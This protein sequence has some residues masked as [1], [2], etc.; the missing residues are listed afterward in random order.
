MKI[1][2]LMLVICVLGVQSCVTTGPGGEKSFIAISDSQEV[3]IGKNVDTEV[4]AKEKILPDSTWQRYLAEVGQK[5][6]KVC[7]RQ[8][9]DYHFAVIE[10]DQIN[11]FATPGGYV[12]FYSGILNMIDNEA[13]LAAVM[14]HEISHVVARHSVKSLQA[15]VGL[16]VLLQLALGEKSQGSWG[17]VAGLAMNLGMT[18]YGR[19]HELEADKFGVFYMQKAGYNPDG[20]R[21]MFGKLAALTGDKQQGFFESLT[22]DHPDTQERLA[23]INAEIAQMPRSVDALPKFEQRYQEMKKRLPPAKK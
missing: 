12:Y 2:R 8:E 9:I 1:M 7:D 18:G 22:S 11:A 23:K 3:E 15:S 10:S 6:V 16:D 21:T 14:A 13:E 4:R 19:S 20:A 17:Q 5:I